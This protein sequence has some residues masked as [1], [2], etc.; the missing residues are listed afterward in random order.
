MK[1]GEYILSLLPGFLRRRDGT[2]TDIERWA[3][4]LGVSLDELKQAI[5]K[6]RRAWLLDTATGQALDLHG[7]D[8]GIPRLPGES[9]DSYRQRLKAAYQTYALGGTNPG[10]VEVLKVMGY[11]N[12]RIHELFKDGVVVPLHNGQNLYNGAARHQGGVRWAEFKIFMG[13]EDGKDYAAAERQA[14]LAA[15]KKVKASHSMLAAL[16]LELALTDRLA[17]KEQQA[18]VASYSAEDGTA[19]P[20]LRHTGAAPYGI[21]HDGRAFYQSGRLRDG[22]PEMTTALE[23][24]PEVIPGHRDHRVAYKHDGG[25]PRHRHSGSLLRMGFWHHNGQARHDGALRYRDGVAHYGDKELVHGGL[26]RYGSGTPRNG[27]ITYGANGLNDG[28]HLVVRR[29]GL[30][31]EVDAA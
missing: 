21:R 19:G 3:E 28:L 26:V 11:P 7:T 1:F 31:V 22:I 13:I 9:D 17:L 30:P 12:A 29:K 20:I 2:K 8:R 27:S 16:A 5:F 23:I 15:I 4:A 18:I 6:V 24:G 25:G 14:L 10:L